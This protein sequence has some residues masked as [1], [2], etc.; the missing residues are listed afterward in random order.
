MPDD[1]P[2]HAMFHTLAS[3]YD[4]VWPGTTRRCCS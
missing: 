2:L 3:L 4:E 1:E